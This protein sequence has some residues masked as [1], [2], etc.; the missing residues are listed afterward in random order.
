[1][2]DTVKSRDSRRAALVDVNSGRENAMKRTL[3]LVLLVA[4]ALTGGCDNAV[5]L[6]PT[7]QP[8]SATLEELA[9][10]DPIALLR[11]SRDRYQGYVWDWQATTTL[12]TE[13]DGMDRPQVFD[14]MLKRQPYAI[15]MTWRSGATRYDRL[16]YAAEGGEPAGKVW[17]HPTGYA[18]GLFRAVQLSPN[19]AALRQWLP[20]RIAPARPLSSG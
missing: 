2:S 13:A 7:T 16:L 20:L 8:A 6:Q 18:G 5:N 14:A 11:L 3:M 1:M 4:A 17:L 15:R 10:T 9:R 19:D 12:A